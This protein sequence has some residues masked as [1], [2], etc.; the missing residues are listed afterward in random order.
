MLKHIVAWK[1]KA[2]AEGKSKTE[3]AAW[4]KKHLEALYGV[5]PELKA[6][7]VGININP[8]EMAYDAVLT[9]SFEDEKALER[10]KIHPEHVKISSYCEKIRESRVVVDYWEE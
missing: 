3:N 4:M 2:E 9:S 6:L 1:L 5:I 8:S 10:Y 7:E